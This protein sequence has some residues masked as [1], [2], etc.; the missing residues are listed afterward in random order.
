MLGRCARS[1]ARAR[2]RP[3]APPGT[4]PNERQRA[5]APADVRVVLEGRA[6]AV[7]LRRARRGREPGSVIATK[8]PP[9]P[10]SEQK[11]ANSDSVSIV[12]P[13]FEETT[14]SVRCEVDLLARPRGS[15]P[16]SVESS[17][18]RRGLPGWC[19]EGAPQHLGRERGA[20]HA[21]Q[22][23][24]AEAL[25]ARPPRRTPRRSSSSVEHPLGD[26]QPAEPVGDLRGA[27][28]PPQRRVRRAQPRGDATPPRRVRASRRPVRAA[29]PECAPRRSVGHRSRHDRSGRGTRHGCSP[30]R[31]DPGIVRMI[32]SVPRRVRRWGGAASTGRPVFR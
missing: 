6:E 8:W 25:R 4:R 19:A 26:R 9:S 10:T 23:G 24:V 30:S 21:E 7:L 31:Y 5:V 17:T 28:R 29:A 27:L 14:N 18:C 2:R 32:V 3:S 16:A 13:D 22:H 15:P 20:A 1:A 11:C 12:P